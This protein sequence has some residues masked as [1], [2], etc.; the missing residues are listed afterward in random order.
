MRASTNTFTSNNSNGMYAKDVDNRKPEAAK[1]P[2]PK[3]SVAKIESRLANFET[4]A[5]STTSAEGTETVNKKSLPK[6]DIVKRRELFEKE[7]EAQLE[8]PFESSSNKAIT[9]LASA[10][11]IKDRVSSLENRDDIKDASVKKLNRLSGEFNRVKDRLSNIESP[12]VNCVAV[13]DK[14]SKVD[15]P[16]VPL[17]ERLFTLQSVVSQ[18][19]SSPTLKKV[20]PQKIAYVKFDELNQN[21][22]GREMDVEPIVSH[23]QL[24]DKEDS[25]IH[26]SDDLLSTSLAHSDDP[27]NDSSS[28]L[29]EPYALLEAIQEEKEEPYSLPPAIVSKKPEVMP[30]TTKIVTP[31]LPPVEPVSYEAED[32]DDSMEAESQNDYN[33]DD[34]QDISVSVTVSEQSLPSITNVTNNSLLDNC[35]EPKTVVEANISEEKNSVAVDSNA[36]ISL[37]I[38]NVLTQHVTISEQSIPDS[39]ESHKFDSEH[40]PHHNTHT[41]QSEKT[42]GSCTD[43]AKSEDVQFVTIT[44][45][46]P[47]IFTPVEDSPVKVTDPESTKNKNQRLKCQIVGVL[48]KNRVPLEVSPKDEVDLVQTLTVQLLSPTLSPS[49]PRSPKSPRSPISPRSPRSPKSPSKTKNIFDFIKRNLLNE[50]TT[51]ATEDSRSEFFVPLFGARNLDAADSDAMVKPNTEIDQLLDDEL[52]KLSGDELQ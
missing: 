4:N 28:F 6:I 19:N 24:A 51:D 14:P 46:N 44:E 45:P 22:N 10:M 20:E 37:T 47:T 32:C 30:R 26:S 16:V 27:F 13:E 3:L 12:I 25:G 15:V 33:D 1:L 38:V 41:D 31:D 18:D 34:D 5:T 43:T 9:E 49:S 39:N 17:K 50:T 35:S 7:A 36:K 23:P 40:S 11:S 2:K 52:S 29:E 42:N 48:E 21:G 8:K